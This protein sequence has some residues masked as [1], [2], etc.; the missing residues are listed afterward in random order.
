MKKNNFIKLV[1]FFICIYTCNSCIDDKQDSTEYSLLN[2]NFIL[3]LDTIAYDYNSLRPAP[4]SEHL[5]KRKSEYAI[6]VYDQFI[7]I[8]VWENS[9]I[10]ALQNDVSVPNEK[11][12][13]LYNKS[14]KNNRKNINIL[15][16]KQ[17]GLYKLYPTKD[18][19]IMRKSGF[20]G[21]IK[22]SEILHN[23]H[24]ALMVISIRDNVKSGIEKLIL[25]E[26]SGGI[27][28]IKNEIELS[29]W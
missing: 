9:I 15:Y 12:I 6:T 8:Q 16:I 4:N 7:N 13:S 17:V 11:Y 27:W 22:F 29:I 20:T 10:K 25:F 24:I 5:E 26:K 23:E 1:M 28:R 14:E 21:H 18:S 19:S 2:Q 3:M